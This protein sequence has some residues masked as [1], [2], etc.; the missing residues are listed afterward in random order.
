ML[1]TQ[2]PPE[3]SLPHDI[4]LLIAVSDCTAFHRANI[5]KSRNGKDY[6][7][8]ER[9]TYNYWTQRFAEA[10]VPVNFQQSSFAKV[11]FCTTTLDT[12]TGQLRAGKTKLRY[13]VVAYDEVIKDLQGWNTLVSSSFMQRPYQILPLC[14][15]ISDGE[16]PIL[17]TA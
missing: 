1:L 5:D 15:T 4:D 11:H 7:L 17:E 2:Q 8:I 9:V 10:W 14:P 3:T 12:E 13:A 16:T 6:K